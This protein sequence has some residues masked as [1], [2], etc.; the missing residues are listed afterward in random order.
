MF[1]LWILGIKVKVDEKNVDEVFSMSNTKPVFAFFFSPYCGHC[2][3]VH[4][5]WTELMDHYQ[6]DPAIVIAECDCINHKEAQNKMWRVDA[7]PTFVYFIKGK[8]TRIRPERS[9]SSFIKVSE[10]LKAIDYSCNYSLDSIASYPLCVLYPAEGV[11]GCKVVQ[12][13][14][15]L[16]PDNSQYIAVGGKSLNET[17][18]KCFIKEDYAIDPIAGD[19]T[20]TQM[21]NY[22]SEHL[23][24]SFK[25]FPL[26]KLLKSKRRVGILVHQDKHQFDTMRVFFQEFN[27][28]LLIGLMDMKDFKI[29]YP[30]N[31]SM[32]LVLNEEKSKFMIVPYSRIN[33]RNL[34]PNFVQDILSNKFEDEMTYNIFKVIPGNDSAPIPNTSPSLIVGS[35]ILFVVLTVFLVKKFVLSNGPKIE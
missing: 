21:A 27:K 17:H 8:G 24:I 4:P 29:N 6:D 35:L 9:I 23:L 26:E 13:L 15:K 16:I 25:E 28:D 3:A 11:N 34:I 2:K 31:E 12:N 32:L 1:L 7:Y 18:F 30:K 14:Q 19:L 22:A 10:D 20:I 5:T 33:N